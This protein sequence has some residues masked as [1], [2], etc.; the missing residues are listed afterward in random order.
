MSIYHL[1]PTDV[2]QDVIN[3]AKQG[4]TLYL[5]PK[6]YNEKVEI[7]TDGLT[8]IGSK[9]K[10]AVY[11][12]DC[13]KKPHPVN[14][15]SNTFSS[16]TLG[17]FAKDVS[18]FD[19][20]IINGSKNPKECGQAVAL[21]VYG[22]NFTMQ[23]CK[24]SALQDTLFLGPLPDDLI[25]RYQ[26]F[27]PDYQRYFEGTITAVFKNVEIL[28][29]VD[30]IFGSANAVFKNCS[31]KYVADGRSVGYISA[32]SHSLKQKDGFIFRNCSFSNDTDSK[33]YLARPWRD[34]GKCSFIDCTYRN[35]A[36][37]LF[38]G[39]GNSQRF[40]TARFEIDQLP[41]NAV[42]WAKRID[43]TELMRLKEYTDKF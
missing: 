25:T 22:D 23:D 35:I 24:L 39:W 40:K 32:P 34:Y 12:C 15:E 5:Y 3:S 18:I 26:G 17:V 42:S 13:A 11:F 43:K 33:V 36:P 21:T 19:L 2:L 16:F 14:Y 28:G 4:D 8:L 29:S 31:V 37:E 41:S 27:L 38:D 10:T 6:T 7:K 20:E 30:F 1:T 9:G